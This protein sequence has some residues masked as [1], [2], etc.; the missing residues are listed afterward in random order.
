[1][2]PSSFNTIVMIWWTGLAQCVFECSFPGSLIP[3]F[4]LNQV[5]STIVDMLKVDAEGVPGVQDAMRNRKR[6]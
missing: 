4:L 5:A 3:M 2:H 1:M 6:G